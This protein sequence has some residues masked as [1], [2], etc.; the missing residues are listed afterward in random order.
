MRI[1]ACF[2][3]TERIRAAAKFTQAGR[4]APLSQRG[5]TLLELLVTLAIVGL[6]AGLVLPNVAAWIGASERA[7]E[8]RQFRSAFARLPLYAYTNGRELA[9]SRWD[10]ALPDAPEIQLPRGWR[11]DLDPSLRV[12]AN[13][14]CSD[15][16]GSVLTPSGRRSFRVR[17][18]DCVV[19]YG[20]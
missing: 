17:A 11:A 8:N 3:P 20:P 4:A 13:G 5:F 1:S 9:V 2:R 19:S 16:S 14:L 15:A 7:T 6:L 12:S 10:G 18:P